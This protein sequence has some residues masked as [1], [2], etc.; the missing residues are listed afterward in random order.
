MGIRMDTLAGILVL[1]FGIL[2]G[3]IG[4][5][6]AGVGIGLP[7]IPIGIYLAWRGYC[8]AKL[9]ISST[10]SDQKPDSLDFERSPR[11]QVGIGIILLL[12]GIGTSALIIGV[13]VAILGCF[14]LYKGIKHARSEKH[15]SKFAFRS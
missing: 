9:A 14:I 10:A 2:V 6:S 1:A 15:G 5:A 4:V 13:P 8:M 12:I 11:G 7:V 3:G